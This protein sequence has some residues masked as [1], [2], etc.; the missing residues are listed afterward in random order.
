M[1]QGQQARYWVLGPQEWPG[2]LPGQKVGLMELG[3][4]VLSLH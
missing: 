4:Q 2:S 3:L 1:F